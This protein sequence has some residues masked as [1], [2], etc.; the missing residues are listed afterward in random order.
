MSVSTDAPRPPWGPGF[1]RLT[2]WPYRAE[3]AVAT[4]VLF[5]MVFYWRGLV[6]G[7]L[8]VPLAIGWVV[9]PD[10]AAFLP[11]G[12]S[13]RG[14]RRWPTWGPT[15]YNVFHS[16]LVWAPVFLLWS[17]LE[18]HVEWPLLGWAG[19]ITADRATGFYLRA[20]PTGAAEPPS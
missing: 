5:L 10:V 15:L 7:D 1:L 4:I 9:F 8:N 17:V 2:A 11:I 3:M 16:L 20:R 19:H 18:G 13:S 14:G 6:V 12:I